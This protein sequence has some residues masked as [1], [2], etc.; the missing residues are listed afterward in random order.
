MR[1]GSSIIAG[2]RSSRRC[3]LH[4]RG[5]GSD[6]V[7][8][9]TGRYIKKARSSDEGMGKDVV[10]GARG[11]KCSR[12]MFGEIRRNGNG[13]IDRKVTQTFLTN[14]SGFGRN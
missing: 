10:V 6:G 14:V 1:R 12:K 13:A 11:G 8:N 7:I 9:L 5:E 4:R 3:D 2:M